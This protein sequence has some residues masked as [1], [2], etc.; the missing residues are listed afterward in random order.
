MTDKK[1]KSKIKAILLYVFFAPFCIGELYLGYKD[2]FKKQMLRYL[3]LIIGFI[4]S[5]IIDSSSLA[6]LFLLIIVTFIAFYIFIVQIINYIKA[7]K[8]LI[9]IIKTDSAGNV[10]IWNN[11]K[12]QL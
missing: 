6:F 1:N 12:I 8:I 11:K 9:G 4:L 10:L 7:I 5:N 3:L 2:K